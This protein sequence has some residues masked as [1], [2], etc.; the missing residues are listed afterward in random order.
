MHSKLRI[1]INNKS[2]SPSGQIYIFQLKLDEL[3]YT[4]GG[5]VRHTD[6]HLFWL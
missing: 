6:E 5:R 1:N 3:F 4:Y 2:E